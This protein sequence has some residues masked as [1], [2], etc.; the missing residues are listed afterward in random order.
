MQTDQLFRSPFG[1]RFALVSCSLL[2]SVLIGSIIV[3][4]FTSLT[5]GI[6]LWLVWGALFSVMLAIAWLVIAETA[7][8]LRL[9]I[10]LAGSE[11][12][13]RLPA[14]RGHARLPQVD[15]TFRYTDIEA[16][17]T[18]REAFRQLGAVAIQQV[19][20]LCLRDGR[21]IVL[22]ADRALR[23]P[24]FGPAA[25]AIAARARLRI[26]DRGM[27]LGKAGLLATA[28]VQVPDWE[29]ESLDPSARREHEQRSVLTQRILTIT[30][31]IF[32]VLRALLR[33]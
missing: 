28:G 22:G 2:I 19:W 23:A 10:T 31:I 15:E 24:L 1:L 5:A 32:T 13:L 27:V 9:R 25:A 16:M 29:A 33:R 6:G 26:R 11:L 30:T 12:Q 7:A 8:A 14:R 4:V 17:E 21:R 18:R 20:T 3:F